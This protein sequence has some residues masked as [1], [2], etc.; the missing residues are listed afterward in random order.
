MLCFGCSQNKAKQNNSRQSNE[1]INESSPYL[2]QHAYN[3]VDWKPWSEKAINEAKSQQK[4]MIISIGYAA[5]HW[6]H[7]MEKESFEND[8]IAKLMNEKFI[9]IKVDREERPDV[10][11][12]YIN[13]VQLMTGSAGWP[14]NCITLPDG[15]PIFGGTYFTKKQWQKILVDISNLYETNPDKVVSYANQLTKGI[16]ETSLIS[17]N[18]EEVEFKERTIQEWVNQLSEQFDFE[19]G[20][21]KNAPKFPMPDYLNFLMKYNYYFKNNDID[22]FLNL[23]LE[24]MSFGGIYD[25]IGGGFSRYSVDEKWHVPHFEKMLY[26]NAQLVSLYSNAYRQTKTENYKTIV[27]ETL[28]FIERELYNSKGGFYSSLDAD[29]TNENDEL[30]EG[31]YY[32]WQSEEL[33]SI[34]KEDYSLFKDYYSIQSSMVWENNNYILNKSRDNK[35]FSQDNNIDI[36]TLESKIKSWK[37]LLLKHREKRDKPRLDD[38]I[39]TSWNALM[40]KGYLDAFK[41]FNEQEY[42]DIALKSAN[43][44]KNNLIGSEGEL[45]HNFKKGKTSVKGFLEDYAIV[46]SSFIDLYEITENKSW[47]EISKSLTEYSISKFYNSEN[48]MFYFTESNLTSAIDRKTE[49]VDNVIPSSNAFMAEN[50]FK[51]GHYFF[52]EG[53]NGK[54]SQMLKNILPTIK[55]NPSS[56]SKWLSLYLNYSQPFYELAISGKGSKEKLQ[57]L[58][59]YYIPN[60][61]VSSSKENSDLPL[62]QNKYVEDETLIYVCTNGVCKLPVNSIGKALKQI[63][64]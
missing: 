60:I 27:Y 51:L 48:G 18:D 14:L 6:C 43:F 49:I 44:I 20:G 63:I 5:C 7:V 24:K 8:S 30:E 1:L 42:L 28:S 41:A 35:T 23:T 29:S 26:D 37:T 53:Y 11:Q 4:L 10:D 19:Y 45:Y 54:S 64:K 52:D 16:N 31:V 33:K 55:K 13:A 36:N 61:L 15:K 2:L 59:S 25:Q 12:V 56:Y 34:L 57:E 62:L 39:L 22:N 46:I 32:T 9:N 38:K 47:L 3:P 21:Q 58:F 50:L 40:I 17:F